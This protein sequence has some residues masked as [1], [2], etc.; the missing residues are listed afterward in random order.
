MDTGPLVLIAV[1]AGLV[2]LCVIWACYAS[3]YQRNKFL[4]G[5]YEA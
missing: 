1:M 4:P 2:A 3:I 5:Q